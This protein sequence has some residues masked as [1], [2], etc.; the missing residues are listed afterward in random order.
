MIDCARARCMLNGGCFVCHLYVFF[1]YIH[2]TYYKDTRLG[3]RVTYWCQK[4]DD[5]WR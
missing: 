1:Y 3:L 4:C 2:Y 5:N